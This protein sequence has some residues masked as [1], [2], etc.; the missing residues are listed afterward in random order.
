MNPPDAPNDAGA[1]PDQ[2]GRGKFG[3]GQTT[4]LYEFHASRLKGGR[5]FTPNVIRVWPDRIEEYEFHALRK[6][7]TRAVG[8][9]QVSE[10]TL[11]RGLVWSNLSIES[12]GGKSIFLEGVPKADAD[13]VKQLID[14]GVARAKIGGGSGAGPSV[15]PQPD[16]ADQLR[17]LAGLRDDGILTDDEFEAQK[18]KLLG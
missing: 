12:S 18:A 4:P 14:D 2:A 7:E 17:K 5:L 13:R 11:A 3:D 8:Y 6:K 9:Q 1:K 15:P 16:L 10:V